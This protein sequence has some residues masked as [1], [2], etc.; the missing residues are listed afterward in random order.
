M[1]N[2]L[3]KAIW[4]RWRVTTCLCGSSGNM[5]PLH[6][7]LQC[8]FQNTHQTRPDRLHGNSSS[9]LQTG[10]GYG[11]F[12]VVVLLRHGVIFIGFILQNMFEVSFDS[13]YV[14]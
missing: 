6:S 4:C 10:S 5:F 1:N 14:C 11:T 9:S 12:L 13:G 3:W 8:L 2:W 7:A